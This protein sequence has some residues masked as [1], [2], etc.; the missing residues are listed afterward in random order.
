MQGHMLLEQCNALSTEA[1]LVRT[2]SSKTMPM[3]Q[4]HFQKLCSKFENFRA[5]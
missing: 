1:S 5:H 2:L 4:T 3:G